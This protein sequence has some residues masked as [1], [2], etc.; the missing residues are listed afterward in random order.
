MTRALALLAAAVG[1][2]GC[3]L[4]GSDD[5]LSPADIEVSVEG[6]F[7]GGE[8]PEYN[9]RVRNVSR[10]TLAVWVRLHGEVGDRVVGEA[11]AYFPDLEPGERGAQRVPLWS[12]DPGPVGEIECTHG[13]LSLGDGTTSIRNQPLERTCR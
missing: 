9:V 1:L 11:S 13:F 2:A 10:R 8:R 7:S 12:Y 6:P 4:G 5:F 3:D